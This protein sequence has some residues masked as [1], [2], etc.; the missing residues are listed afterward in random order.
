MLN[1]SSIIQ[2]QIESITQMYSMFPADFQQRVLG[3]LENNG[4]TFMNILSVIAIVLN[5]FVI[6][7]ALKNEVLKKKGKLIAISV[8]CLFTANTSTSTLL[9]IINIIVLIALKRVNPEDFPEPRKEIPHLEYQKS[10]KK[11]LITGIIFTAIYFSQF[12]FSQFIP[13]D[14]ILALGGIAIVI[15]ILLFVL[16]I[17]FFK[18]KLKRDIKLFKENHKAYFGYVLPKLGIMYLLFIVS[19]FICIF[20]T[21]TATSV[22]QSMLEDMPIWFM[23]PLAIIWAPIVEELIFRGVLRRFIKSDK[24]FILI[25][26]II[27]GL[28][29]TVHEETLLNTIVMAIP[30]GVLG[31]YVAYIYAKTDNL[32]TNILSHAFINAVATVFT[33]LISFIIW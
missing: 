12:L 8:I 33:S 28:L 23:A 4:A 24:V 21:K 13:E 6:K 16:A 17:I 11:E 26:A 32:C 14:N 10:T 2:T 19:N 15:Y 31:G 22:N 25:S 7:I 29:H 27:F 9:S 1:S 3:M 5:A 20:I 30:Y 18:D